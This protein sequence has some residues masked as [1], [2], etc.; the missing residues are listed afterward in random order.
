MDESSKVL[1]VGLDVHKDSIAVAYAPAERGTEVVSLGT[2][3]PRQCDVDKLIRKLQ[4]KGAPELVFAYEAGPC[5]YGLYRSLTRKGF[6][7]H[8]VAPSLIPR[9]AGDRVKTDRRDALMLARLLRSDD[10][11]PVY[12]PRPEDEALRDL[13]RARE[14][15]LGD[16]KR[17]KRRL[18][19]FLL[20]HDVRYGGRASWN[21][22]HLRW[23]AQVVCPLPAQ[24]IVF[25]E[26]LTA[27]TQQQERKERLERELHAAVAGWRLAPV[28]DAL[29]A[30]R[31]VELTGAIIILMA[32]LGDITRF[33]TPR[34]LMSYLGLTPTEA[35]TG[36]RRRQGGIT[37]AGN[38]H[39]V[40]AGG[41]EVGRSR[42]GKVA[43]ALT[44]AS[45]RT[46]WR[47]GARRRAADPLGAGLR[48]AVRGQGAPRDTATRGRPALAPPGSGSRRAG[49]R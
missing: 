36:D 5:G 24:Q 27:V 25:Q 18:K 2:I 37:K 35:S 3:G 16:L 22:A 9:K 6:V 44:R 45:S 33:D 15:V 38:G 42:W 4:G 13:S 31:G 7:C 26:Y 39:A 43:P 34:Q 23:L 10:L 17:S 14:D 21:A 1:Y 19:S 46:A 41:G 40:T 28:V 32:E 48:P 47:S 29:Q 20:R 11:T 49:R 12:V 8:V 30:R